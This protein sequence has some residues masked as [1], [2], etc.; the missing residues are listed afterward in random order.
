VEVGETPGEIKAAAPTLGQH[1]RS[2]LSDLLGFDDSRIVNMRDSGVIGTSPVNPRASRQASN[3]M[4]LSQ[5][6]IVRW[7]P[8]FEE[9]VRRKFVDQ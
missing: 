3:E 7:E 9:Q 2:V 8:D 5:G 1:N 6:R 4:L